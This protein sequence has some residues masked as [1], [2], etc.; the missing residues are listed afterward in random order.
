MA[1]TRMLGLDFECAD[2]WHYRV[3]LFLSAAKQNGL[4]TKQQASD[5]LHN[6]FVNET[7]GPHKNVGSDYANEHLNHDCKDQLDAVPNK[8]DPLAQQRAMDII[9][10]NR[11]IDDSLNKNFEFSNYSEARNKPKEMLDAIN[12][13]TKELEAHEVFKEQINNPSRVR[14]YNKKPRDFHEGKAIERY[15]LYRIRYDGDRKFIA[16][17]DNN[18]VRMF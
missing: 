9:G 3:E 15:F 18:D 4:I 7:G 12:R 2:D 6:C 10:M 17:R 16:R 13:A 11:Q 5:I 8:E 14:L 1:I